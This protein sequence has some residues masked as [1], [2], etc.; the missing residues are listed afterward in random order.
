MSHGYV[1]IWRKIE[2]SGILGNADVCQ[3]FM[4]LLIKATHRERKYSVGNQ[5]INLLPGQ[6]V[7]GRKQ[8]AAVLNSSEQRVRTA[9]RF[10][11]IHDI[12]SQQATNKFTIISI[13]NW[14]KYQDEQSSEQPAAN[15]QP[16]NKQP[17]TQPSH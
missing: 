13:I 2:D 1:K 11:E 6:F 14:R 9:L 5:V 16:T 7:T 17:A 8:L 12:I 3:L 15:Q 4:Y 10:L